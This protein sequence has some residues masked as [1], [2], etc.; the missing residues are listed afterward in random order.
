M[1]DFHVAVSQSKNG[2]GRWGL[3]TQVCA[4]IVDIPHQPRECQRLR[5]VSP[6]ETSGGQLLMVHC[7]QCKFFRHLLVERIVSV[8]E[9][10]V[11]P[12]KPVSSRQKCENM[13]QKQPYPQGQSVYH[14]IPATNTALRVTLTL[15][16]T[17]TA[18]FRASRHG[19]QHYHRTS[20]SK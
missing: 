18:L 9:S 1:R 17:H 11:S 8:A 7:Q 14:A 5:S 15:T 13:P 12:C 3:E 16:Y 4:A 6:R 2:T 20:V 19:R 10:I